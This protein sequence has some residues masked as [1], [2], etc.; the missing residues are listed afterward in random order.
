MDSNILIRSLLV[1]NKKI[2]A[3]AG[4][5]I[6]AESNLHSEYKETFQKLSKIVNFYP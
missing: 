2:F 3:W 6:V 5:G 1:T 4:G